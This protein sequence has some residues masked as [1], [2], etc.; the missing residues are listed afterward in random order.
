MIFTLN[1]SITGLGNMAFIRLLLIAILVKN[2]IIEQGNMT[3][4]YGRIEKKKVLNYLKKSKKLDTLRQKNL[5][6]S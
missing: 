2:A 1:N 5:N 3:N 4:I 6:R